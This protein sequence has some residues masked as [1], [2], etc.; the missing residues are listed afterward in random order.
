FFSGSN[1]M[2][3]L[4]SL[5]VEKQISDAFAF[6]RRS[7]DAAVQH[8]G[9]RGS[10]RL[11]TARMG[12]IAWLRMWRTAC[13]HS[14]GRSRTW[15]QSKI[16]AIGTARRNSSTPSRWTS[17]EKTAS[18]Q[19]LPLS[20]ALRW[21]AAVVLEKYASACTLKSIDWAWAAESAAA[22]RVAPHI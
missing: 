14:S 5:P 2:Q 4:D 12:E 22:A 11:S 18:S 7:N 21:S 3:A 20:V 13:C 15:S 9:T 8:P 1:A 17:N 10:Q 6:W 19:E 16:L